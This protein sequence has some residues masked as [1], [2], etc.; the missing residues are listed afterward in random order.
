L[1]DIRPN[2]VKNKLQQGKCATVVGGVI[3][4]EVVDFL[5]QFGFDGA[6]LDTEHG[7]YGWEEVANMTRAC[8]LWGMT[9][10]ARVHANEAGL[11]TRTLDAGAT[12]IAVPHVTTKEEAIRAARAVK[13]PP[14][15]NRGMS[16]GRQSYGVSGFHQKAN[17]ESIVIA[18]IEDVEAVENLDEIL[19]VDGIDVFLVGAGDL[20]ASLGYTG[21][22]THPEVVKTVDSCISRIVAAGRTA[23]AVVQQGAIDKR[24]DQG[25]R[26]LLLTW[27]PWV[28][29]GA[30]N[31]MATIAAKE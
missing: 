8:D 23:G 5:G 22:Q 29:D 3:S 9:P 17:D 4:A 26:Y 10:V 30:K 2:R 28:S 12:G 11:I 7:P 27:H 18:F 25:V 31:Y 6:W 13:Y 20:S 16:S 19:T 24:I 14:E 1:A 21:Q 15:G